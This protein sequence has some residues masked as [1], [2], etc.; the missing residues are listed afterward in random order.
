[1]TPKPV[2]VMLGFKEESSVSTGAFQSAPPVAATRGF[3]S[4]AAST[5]P[6]HGVSTISWEDPHTWS[7][8]S[9]KRKGRSLICDECLTRK[10]VW[11]FTNEGTDF[12]IKRFCWSCMTPPMR[13]GVRELYTR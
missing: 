7:E 9:I 10:T 1:M 12:L 4:R 5:K 8:W 11:Q 6:K 13:R 2:D 3:S